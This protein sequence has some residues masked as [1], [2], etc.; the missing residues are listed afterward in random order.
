V[1]GVDL[2]AQYLYGVVRIPAL[3]QQLSQLTGGVTIAVISPDPQLTDRP[4][5]VQPVRECFLP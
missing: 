3:D 4:P 1:T 2:G 5:A